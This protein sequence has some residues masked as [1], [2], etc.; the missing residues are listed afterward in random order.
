M[1]DSSLSRGRFYPK[2]AFGTGISS[3]ISSANA[4][5]AYFCRLIPSGTMRFQTFLFSVALLFAIPHR[6]QAQIKQ[7]SEIGLWAGGTYS[8]T[9]INNSFQHLPMVREGGGIFYRWNFH[10]RWS[11]KPSFSYGYLRGADSL[12]NNILE[13]RRNLSYRNLTYDLSG[14][15][16]FNFF[17]RN[18]KM[19]RDYRYFTPYLGMGFGLFYHNPQAYYQGQWQDL[20]P[21]GTEGQQFAELGFPEPYRRIGI[22]VPISGGLKYYFSK[23]WAAGLEVS[24]HKTFT[25]YLDDVSTEYVDRD[26]LLSGANGALAAALADRS[27]EMDIPGIGEPPG[28]QRGDS[29]RKDAYMFAGI[30]LSYVFAELVC[31][32]PSRSR[33]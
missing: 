23:H 12:S 7:G 6:G 1:E 13:S 28:R 5:I 29:N 22:S 11:L 19:Y 4:I 30:T 15:I 10:D 9:D 33:F 18:R 8:F 24:F 16:E 17:K 26:L 27:T 14:T 2:T 25:D 20:R 32:P 21:L 3:G 31:P